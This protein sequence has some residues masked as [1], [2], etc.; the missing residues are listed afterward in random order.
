MLIYPTPTDGGAHPVRSA[1]RLHASNASNR[2][3]LPLALYSAAI[4]AIYIE[5]YF[6]LIDSGPLAEPQDLHCS[7]DIYMSA[8]ASRR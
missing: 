2:R 5:R 7:N 1:D 3:R 8:T 4:L 6:E